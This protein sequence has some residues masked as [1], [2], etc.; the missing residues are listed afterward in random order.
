MQVILKPVSHPQW[1]EIV[2]E[3]N[4][5]AIGRDETPFQSFK[6]DVVAKLSRRHARLFEEN[7]LVY[8]ADMGSSNGTTLNNHRVHDRPE[9]VHQ[10]DE[11][12]FAD[13]LVYR[14]EI[15]GEQEPSHVLESA[16]IELVLEPKIADLGIEPIVVTHFPFLI[17]KSDDAF[18]RYKE[19][20]PNEVNYISRRHAHMFLKQDDLYIEDLGSTNGTFVSGE[21]LD[22]HARLL[23]NG[24]SVAFGGDQFIYKVRLQKAKEEAFADEK[25][26]AETTTATDQKMAADGSKTT[27]VSTATSFLDIFCVQDEASDQ[28][29]LNAKEAK[30]I[31]KRPDG[32]LQPAMT[33]GAGSAAN[34]GILNKIGTFV[35]EFKEAFSEDKPG[36]K[37]GLWI[38]MGSVGVV[39]AVAIGVYSTG[40][41]KREIKRLLEQ[42]KYM[43]S[44]SIANQILKEHPANEQVSALATEGLMKAVVPAWKAKLL[45]EQFTAANK[46]LAQA[47]ETSQFNA[48][49]L[50]LLEVLQWMTDLE[51]FV[52]DRGGLVAPIIMFKHEDTIDHLVERWKTYKIKYQRLMSRIL[53]Y[54]PGFS[55][56]ESS[57]ISHLRTL[58]LEQSLYLR[59][60]K[61]LK[62][63]IRQKLAAGVPREVTAELADFERKYPKVTGTK[64]LREDLREYLELFNA[65][66][67]KNLVAVLNLRRHIKFRTPLFKTSTE[68]T[69]ATALPPERV[70]SGYQKAAEA[71]RKGYA[72]QAIAILEPL[73]R[74]SWGELAIE[75]RQHFQ[76]VLKDYELL[77]QSRE[78]PAYGYRVLEF[79]ASLQSAEDTYY[80]NAIKD[81]F[82][83]HKEKALADAREKYDLA[84]QNWQTYQNN[85]GISGIARVEDSISGNYRQQAQRLK[86]ACNQILRSHRIYQLLSLNQSIE[87]QSLRND[88]LAESRRQRQWLNDL[89]FVLKPSLL[90]AKLQLLPKPQQE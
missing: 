10:G 44:V 82:I 77:K 70:V 5:F 27:F 65:I 83:T 26:Q 52:V 89:K 48:Q 60:I 11:L 32:K 84:S 87:L 47:R 64:A 45:A 74:Q 31:G 2:I 54:S 49:G 59:A 39:L 4:L 88:I 81:D 72:S 23:Q 29:E 28:N 25:T 43:E 71:W 15:K 21:R 8:I 36:S 41:D 86:M 50:S 66:E 61:D 18:S 34:I 68:N 58:Q 79:Y 24:D 73:T 56:V 37:R 78:D 67:E 80:I 55:D 42:G 35:R 1:G 85:G 63:R 53:E 6:G 33:K 14:V 7:G 51:R 9:R 19:R 38:G 12:R 69:V 90:Q 57:A 22:E 46:I 17:S 40:A 20:F 3:D 75:K 76:K 30:A 13:A 62:R 16:A